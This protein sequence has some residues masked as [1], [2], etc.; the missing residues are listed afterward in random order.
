MEVGSIAFSTAL[1]N[2]ELEKQ[3][4]RT[5]REIAKL[6]QIVYEQKGKKSPL[7][8][9][10]QEL[11]QKMKAARAEVQRYGDVWRS[12]VPGA[13]KDQSEAA[14]QVRQ[15]EA[16]YRKVTE[17]I[18]KVDKKLLPAQ[19]KL[20]EMM[21]AAGGIEKQ[22]A[23]AG[24]NA[25][26]MDKATK[27]A[28][29][30]ARKF[31]LRLKEVVRSA[32]VFTLITQSLEKLREWTG[33]VIKT[34]DEATKAVSRLKGALLTL[35]Q[36]IVQAVM[37]AFTDFVNML[38]NIIGFIATLVSAIFGLTGKSA[39]DAAEGLHKETEALESMGAAATK[40]SGALAGFDEVNRLMGETAGSGSGGGQVIR[41]DFSAIEDLPKWLK[42]LAADLAIKIEDIRFSWKA[43]NL[44]KNR[45]AWIIALSAIL[46]AVIGSM[47]G[48]I[49][50][51]VIG[52][53]LGASIGIVS[54][55]FLDKTKNADR[56]KQLFI[57][58]LSA[59]LGAILGGMF[60]GLAGGVIGLLLGATISIVALEFTKGDASTWDP[61][62]TVIVILSAI[63][64]AVL[65]TMF[66]G[67]VGGVIG[68][69]L[70]AL[71]SFVS[72]QFNE[73]KFNKDAAIASLRIAL[74]AIL[75]V[76]LGTMFGGL[77][78]GVLGL[79][80]GLTVGFASVAFDKNLE[81]RVKSAASKALKI[82]L[83]TIIGALIGA[84]FGG[85]VF[86]AI[87]GG[88]IGLSFGLA[89]TL[90]SASIKNKTGFSNSRSAGFSGSGGISGNF[91]SANIPSIS[92]Y[93]IP[94]LAAG[95]VIPPNREFMAV[96]GDNKR[97]PE[98]VSPLSTMK[99]ALLEALQESGASGG[100]PIQV[101]LVVDGK[102]LARV[103]VPQINNMTR[104]AG[105]PVLL[106]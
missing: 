11:Q 38:A 70:G 6:E 69:L 85:G 95:S 76:I 12:G 42:N 60:G 71:I 47:F 91:R 25:E 16:Q 57:V 48:G 9:Q 59:L 4:T 102:T 66:G 64:G 22:I 33:K 87:V 89:V 3:L 40:A 77:V 103:V 99:Q 75:G 80:L 68:F 24:G 81:A 49:V 52:L 97:E 39:A 50:G 96:L 36:P 15:L 30:S 35:A 63:L 67:L 2:N 20:D 58:A 56:Y 43:G 83:T 65:G 45:D 27:K 93:S 53:L 18:D 88:V 86:G 7:V 98:V 100:T 17:E 55:V 26:Q 62:N 78:G 46:G 31:A 54:C 72:I 106:L 29:N 79:L 90:N 34:N 32:L 1:D 14:F 10:A 84:V 23:Q 94:R 104:S 37:P 8:Q 105:K 21:A 44:S 101:N 74:F 5:K 73:G 13:D 28:S 51:A 41:P 82:A 92:A 19:G 61:K